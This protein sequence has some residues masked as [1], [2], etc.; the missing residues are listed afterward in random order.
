MSIAPQHLETLSRLMFH[1][2]GTDFHA[3]AIESSSINVDLA[4]VSELTE[5][6][7]SD[8]LDAANKHHVL[9]RALQV[10]E[11]AAAAK[12]NAPVVEWC[13]ASLSRERARIDH[14]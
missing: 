2:Y 11:K 3:P 7:R 14:A 12:Q 5:Q 10:L 9:V 13:Q 1:G 6:G 8:F 4:Y